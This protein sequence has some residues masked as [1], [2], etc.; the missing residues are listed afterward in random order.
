MTSKFQFKIKLTATGIKTSV[1][2]FTDKGEIIKSALISWS[3][4]LN[5]LS[6]IDFLITL[7]K[8]K[9]AY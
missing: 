2:I 8:L 1:Q 6:K 3:D 5:L 9:L 4:I 7:I